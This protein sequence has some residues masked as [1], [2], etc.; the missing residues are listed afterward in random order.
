MLVC[1]V[2]WVHITKYTMIEHIYPIAYLGGSGGSFLSSWLNQAAYNV[3]VLIHEC[4]GNA[5]GAVIHAGFSIFSSQKDSIDSLKSRYLTFPNRM[6]IATHIV[7]DKLLLSNFTKFTKIVYTHED[8]IDIAIS[9]C[10]KTAFSNPPISSIIERI[11]RTEQFNKTMTNPLPETYQASNVS[12]KELLYSDGKN[13]IRRLSAF[14]NI[15]PD[16]FNTTVLHKWQ[17][18]TLRNITSIKPLVKI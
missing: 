14:Y 3:P 7:D 10:A 18:L 1:K 2:L 16:K 13:L 17:K 12:W 11:R 6:F 8:I 15:D 9:F 4:T 5:H